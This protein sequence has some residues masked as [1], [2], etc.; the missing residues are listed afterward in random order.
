MKTETSNLEEATQYWTPSKWRRERE[1]FDFRACA[2]DC[3][4]SDLFEPYK[5]PGDELRECLLRNTS[6]G[7]PAAVTVA[8]DD[9][10][11]EVSPLAD[12]RLDR[13]EVAEI[14]GDKKIAAA[15]AQAGLDPDMLKAEA[16]D[17]FADDESDRPDTIA[18][19][20]GTRGEVKEN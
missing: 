18:S 2:E 12:I 11:F 17:P 3:V 13:V 20:A 15:S 5:R 19:V 16:L 8:D 1:I 7:A 10:S 4:P 9:G 6:M 14:I